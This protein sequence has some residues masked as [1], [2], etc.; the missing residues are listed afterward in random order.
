MLL[1]MIYGGTV[2]EALISTIKRA[3]STDEPYRLVRACTLA[4]PL[5]F[6]APGPLYAFARLTRMSKHIRFGAEPFVTNRT[7]VV[8]E[9]L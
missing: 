5:F 1:F 9:S 7:D 4:R 8:F 2:I 6:G 3:Q